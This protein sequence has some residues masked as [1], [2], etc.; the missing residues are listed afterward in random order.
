MKRLGN[1]SNKCLSWN[2]TKLLARM[3]PRGE[4]ILTPSIWRYMISLKLKDTYFVAIPINSIKTSSGKRRAIVDGPR[5]KKSVHIDIV[6]SKR[7]FVN[8]ET[9]SNETRNWDSL[10]TG[11]R[12]IMEENVKESFTQHPE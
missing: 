12:R 6:S 9:T 11:S 2:P 3:A 7:M 8:N 4:S 1:L 10:H 5:Y